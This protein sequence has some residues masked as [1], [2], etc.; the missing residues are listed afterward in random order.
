MDWMSRV[1]EE[2]IS[3]VEASG[4]GGYSFVEK[5]AVGIVILAVEMA[6]GIALPVWRLGLRPTTFSRTFGRSRLA[7]SRVS[8][9]LLVC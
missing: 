3:Q 1:V 2:R 6:L 7:G 4:S 8:S 5:S 9:R